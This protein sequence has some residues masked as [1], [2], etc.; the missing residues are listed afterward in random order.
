MR[1][2]ICQ[3]LVTDVKPYRERFERVQ[4]SWIV[5]ILRWDKVLGMCIFFHIF[6]V[7]I[8]YIYIYIYI[9]ASIVKS[10]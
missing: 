10:H 1:T 4:V 5:T 6:L 3:D 9:M 7:Y 2:F 8:I